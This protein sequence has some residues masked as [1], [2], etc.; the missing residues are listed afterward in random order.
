MALAVFALTTAIGLLASTAAPAATTTCPDTDTPA[1]QLSLDQFDASMSCLINEVRTD[2]GVQTL[3]P[4]P[5]LRRA[6]VAYTN[7]LLRGRFFS[8]HG[9]FAGHPRSST[10][11]GRL[12][13][14]VYSGRDTSVSRGRTSAGPRP[15]PARPPTSLRCG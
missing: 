15:R 13:Q 10:L 1:A 4:N 6:A 3:R 11:I 5:L 2:S 9:D 14:I 12:R 8:H 7:S